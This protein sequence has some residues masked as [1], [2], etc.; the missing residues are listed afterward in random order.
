[1]YCVMLYTTVCT[2]P[3]KVCSV[4]IG[5][6]NSLSVDFAY[7]HARILVCECVI[8]SDKCSSYQHLTIYSLGSG[9]HKHLP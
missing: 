6:I 3:Y 8:A 2:E 4:E 7:M 5:I 9:R 1:M